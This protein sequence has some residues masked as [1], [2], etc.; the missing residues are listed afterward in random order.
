MKNLYGSEIDK[1]IRRKEI[2]RYG[3]ALIFARNEAKT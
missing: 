3:R 2:A 1:V